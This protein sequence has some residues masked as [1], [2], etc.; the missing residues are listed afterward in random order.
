MFRY[1]NTNHKINLILKIKLLTKKIYDLTKNQ[2]F[3]IKV[4]VNKMLKFFFIRRNSL[5]YATFVLIIKKLDKIFKVYV[6]YKALNVLIIKNRNCF[7]LIKKILDRFCAAKFYIKL[8]VITIFNEI[9][10]RKKWR[11]KDNV[12]NQIRIIRISRYVFRFL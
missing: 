2:I 9:R 6:N 12:F 10:I 3:V 8:N 11:K 7:S 4:Y 5:N 1:Y